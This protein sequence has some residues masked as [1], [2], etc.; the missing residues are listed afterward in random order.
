VPSSA[1]W[2]A[3]QGRQAAKARDAYYD[4]FTGNSGYKGQRHSGRG[5]G[6]VARRG[7]KEYYK[8]F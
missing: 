1:P 7:V 6:E 2:G 4:A 3:R 5:G 8:S